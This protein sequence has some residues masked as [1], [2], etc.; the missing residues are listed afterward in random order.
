[1]AASEE[2]IARIESQ[3]RDLLYQ[4]DQERGLITTLK[5]V[6]APIRKVPVELLVQIFHHALGPR[7]TLKQVLVLSHVCAFWRQVACKSPALW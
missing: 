7:A 4:R 1:I 6:I 2:K 5:L 3:I